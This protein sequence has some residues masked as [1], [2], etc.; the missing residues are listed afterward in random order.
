MAKIG[1]VDQ[2]LKICIT[3][4]FVSLVKLLKLRPIIP[5]TIVW[6]IERGI[7]NNVKISFITLLPIIADEAPK[8]PNLVILNPTFIAIFCPAKTPIAEANPYKGNTRYAGSDTRAAETIIPIALAPTTKEVNDE[9]NNIK[10]LYIL[11]CL[12]IFSFVFIALTRMKYKNNENPMATV[13]EIIQ[14]I[15]TIQNFTQSISIIP[16]ESNVRTAIDG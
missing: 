10:F 7:P 16:C 11:T 12:T 8:Y 4:L 9:D 3:C 5:P 14:E 6:V 1:E 13:G 15:T 2:L